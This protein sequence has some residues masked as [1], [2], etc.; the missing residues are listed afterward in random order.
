MVHNT[1]AKPFKFRY[2]ARVA[3]GK[4]AAIARLVVNPGLSWAEEVGEADLKHIRKECK[5]FRER[6]GS[7]EIVLMSN[8]K[9]AKDAIAK[10]EADAVKADRERPT[11][12]IEERKRKRLRVN[13]ERASIRQRRILAAKADDEAAEAKAEKRKPG[14]PKPGDK[15]TEDDEL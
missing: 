10:R 12:E 11:N 8:P 9:P 6:E 2:R 14:K 7:G 5:H 13:A 15:T 1:T 3:K 4:K